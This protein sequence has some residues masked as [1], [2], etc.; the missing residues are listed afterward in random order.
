MRRAMRSSDPKRL[1]KHSLRLPDEVEAD[2]RQDFVFYQEEGGLKATADGNEPM[3]V[4]YYVGVID[5]LTPWGVLKRVEG[6]WKG[7]RAGVERVSFSESYVICGF[8]MHFLM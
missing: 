4:I 7:V 2:H 1:G 8:L 5:I 6:F 3:D